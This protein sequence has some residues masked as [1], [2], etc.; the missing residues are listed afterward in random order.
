[1]KSLSFSV[2]AL[3]LAFLFS[4]CNSGSPPAECATAAI[5]G[6]LPA[7][8]HPEAALL[9]I[10]Q[11]GYVTGL[12]SGA[13]I[14]P[15][16]VLTAGHCVA[17]FTGWDVTAP[18][19][20]QSAKA[21]AG[22]TFDWTYNGND[23]VT[24]NQHD[25]GLVYLDTAIDLPEYPAIANA[26]VADGTNIVNLG[27]IDDG[28]VSGSLYVSKPLAASGAARAGFPFDYVTSKV[29]ELGD[30]GGPVEV[31]D[32]ALHTIVA[33]NSGVAGNTELL[34]R[35]DLLR[36]WIQ[37][38]IAAHGGEGSTEPPALVPAA[39]TSSCP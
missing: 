12:C 24:Q 9:Q 5:V 2:R 25:V 33:V 14:A 20:N 1:V 3:A 8:T 4:A 19:A 32:T 26:P 16:V 10:T 34:A 37:D 22:E 30:S 31:A 38:R 23:H 35:V 15:K 17:S 39:A 13:L 28:R 6:G 21:S 29:I 18:I 36:T 11:H 7:S 27:I